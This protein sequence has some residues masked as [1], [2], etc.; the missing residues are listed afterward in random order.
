MLLE[1]R[2]QKFSRL[3]KGKLWFW[4]LPVVLVL[5]DVFAG[6]KTDGIT[7]I[8]PH[9]NS[10]FFR[11]NQYIILFGHKGQIPDIIIT[12]SADCSHMGISFFLKKLLC[13]GNCFFNRNFGRA[14]LT[15]VI[16][17]DQQPAIFGEIHTNGVLLIRS[18]NSCCIGWPFGVLPI[19]FN[20]H[21]SIGARIRELQRLTFDIFGSHGGTSEHFDGTFI[22]DACY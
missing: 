16:I 19:F 1:I 7:C 12:I 18:A 8:Q 3:C 22:V 17:R 14:N 2:I 10:H 13:F 11:I 9:T 15:V 5:I 6:L 21:F 4:K 20:I